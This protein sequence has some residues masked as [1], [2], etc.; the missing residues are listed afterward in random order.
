MER[1]CIE[2]RKMI[3]ACLS[4]ELNDKA[5]N[6]FLHHLDECR[7]CMEE[8]EINFIVQEGVRLLDEKRSDSNLDKA[9]Q[10][11]LKKTAAYIRRKKRLLRLSY[12]ADTCLFWALLA[13]LFVYIRISLF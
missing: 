13:V 3:P 5:L 4:G 12:V 10:A 2:F 11:Y 1:N 8:T 6:D 7:D 9:Y